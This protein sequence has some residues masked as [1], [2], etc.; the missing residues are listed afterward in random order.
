[1][2]PMR[3]GAKL[4]PVILVPKDAKS[5]PILLT[6]TPYNATE[7]TSHDPRG[8][9]LTN[10]PPSERVKISLLSLIL[11]PFVREGVKPAN[12]SPCGRKRPPVVSRWP[13]VF[14]CF[15]RT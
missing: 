7:L 10:A 5:P 14:L 8:G 15:V 6:R 9:A 12:N 2:L 3:D 1:M 4:H 11:I 13:R